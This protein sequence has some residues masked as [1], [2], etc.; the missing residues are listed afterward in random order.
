MPDTTKHEWTFA[1]AYP[2]EAGDFLQVTFSDDSDSIDH[3]VLLSTQ[4]EFPQDYD[5]QIE[6][7][8]GD[9]NAQL[10]VTDA[11]LSRTNL[12]I[13]ALTDSKPVAIRITFR[14]SDE[15]FA[16]LKRVIKIMLPQIRIHR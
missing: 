12:S 13:E 1:N 15:D 3:Y 14:T 9:W 16:E 5:I 4:F 7:D 11:I 6:A 8:G 10:S 2:G